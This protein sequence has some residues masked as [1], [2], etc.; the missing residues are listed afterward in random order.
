MK[1]ILVL[2]FALMVNSVYAED[3]KLIFEQKYKSKISNKEKTS[4]GTLIYSFPKKIRIEI[5]K[6]DPVTFVSNGVKSWY[7][8][9]PFMDGEPGEVIVNQGGESLNLLASFFDSLQKG[10]EKNNAYEVVKKGELV[11]LSFYENF[12]KKIKVKKAMLSFSDKTLELSKLQKMEL[13]YDNNE[14]GEFLINKF[15]TQNLDIKTFEFI[16]PENTKISK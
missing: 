5:D 15:E 8:R 9:P 3:F 12:R 10:F 14:K 2:F 7:Y 4:K 1:K 11:E 13:I 16:I 6:P